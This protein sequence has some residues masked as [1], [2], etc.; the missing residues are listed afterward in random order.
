MRRLRALFAALLLVPVLASPASASVPATCHFNAGSFTAAPSTT[1]NA[2]A[3]QPGITCSNAYVFRVHVTLE[4]WVAGRWT[5]D[6]GGT[7][8]VNYTGK[9][10]A[11]STMILPCH[12][13][14]TVRVHYSY[15]L[16]GGSLP[17]GS[18]SRDT[19]SGRCG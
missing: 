13:G 19:L 10:F 15:Q 16:S 2:S 18:I 5:L 8:I 7:H 14:Y 6:I 11:A 17:G 3:H 4:E 9:A 12:H 1:G